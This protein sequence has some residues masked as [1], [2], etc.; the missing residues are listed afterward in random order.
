[1]VEQVV[2][3]IFLLLM[4]YQW[5]SLRGK[6]PKVI[7]S[8]AMLCFTCGVF[9]NIWHWQE[10]YFLIIAG[11]IVELLAVLYSFIWNTSKTERDYS[12]TM[13]FTL[14][15]IQYLA[16]NELR[17]WRIWLTVINLVVFA[18]GSLCIAFKYYGRNNA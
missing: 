17:E 3:F 12:Q 8:L 15:S 13:F 7:Y 16:L 2:P 11:V 14:V 1:M 10:A 5:V 18:V 4:L 9:L 6:L